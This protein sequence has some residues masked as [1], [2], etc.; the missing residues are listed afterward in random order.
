MEIDIKG[1]NKAKLLAA[2]YNNSHPQ[3]M[4]FTQYIPKDMTEQEAETLL[5]KQSYFDY[6]KG[7]VMKIDLSEDVLDPWGYDRDNGEGAVARIVD[8]LRIGGQDEPHK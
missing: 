1:I 8:G 2:L 6:L 7:R 4:G 5:T 3:G